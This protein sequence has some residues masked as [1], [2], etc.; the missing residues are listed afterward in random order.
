[1][2]KDTPCQTHQHKPCEW[3]SCIIAITV[4]EIWLCWLRAHPL[5]CSISA[6]FAFP[7]K[8]YLYQIAR[9]TL[10]HETTHEFHSTQRQTI[11]GYLVTDGSRRKS[12]ILVCNEKRW[13]LQCSWRSGLRGCH[14]QAGRA[15]IS[16]GWTLRG[17]PWLR[18][19]PAKQ[20]RQ[21]AKS[22]RREGQLEA[23]EGK[24]RLHQQRTREESA[25]AVCRDCD[26]NLAVL[27]RNNSLIQWQVHCMYMCVCI[28]MLCVCI[29]RCMYMH[30][31]I[32]I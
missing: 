12:L 4:V 7:V 26:L 28:Y 8:L 3:W 1:M 2:P 32:Y 23:W 10:K 15:E 13:D 14:H 21:S 29:Y 16:G 19:Y 31:Y 18:V 6:V 5:F 11:V 20:N 17:W 24:T 25:S 27:R 9:L 22:A 30:I